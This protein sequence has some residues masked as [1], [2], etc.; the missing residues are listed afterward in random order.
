MTTTT[1]KENAL[2]M[3]DLLREMVDKHAMDSLDIT[4]HG[5]NSYVPSWRWRGYVLTGETQ[6]TITLNIRDEQKYAELIK[7]ASM[8]G[9]VL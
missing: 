3:I 9:R 5:S 7:Q 1:D 4:V 2:H 8:Y 6:V